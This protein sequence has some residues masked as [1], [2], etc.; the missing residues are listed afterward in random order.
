MAVGR[1]V[2][3]RVEALALGLRALTTRV[4]ALELVAHAPVTFAECPVCRGL[5]VEAR[6][7]AHV[8]WHGATCRRCGAAAAPVIDAD[9]A[10]CGLCGLRDP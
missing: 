4:A 2:A 8:E 5:V 10:R 6:F 1:R 7:D 9:G 3:R